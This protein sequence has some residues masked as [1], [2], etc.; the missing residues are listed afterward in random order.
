MSD[1]AVTTQ[2]GSARR[3]RWLAGPMAVLAFGLLA[4]SALAFT[5]GTAHG[6]PNTV[7]TSQSDINAGR[8]LYVAHCQSC[9]G[10]NGV[11][12]TNSSP[13]L[14]DAGAAAADFYLSTGRMPL[15]N[16]SDEAIR[17]RPYFNNTEIRQLVAYV[18]ALPAING[19][20]KSGA[21]IPTI[22]PVCSAGQLSQASPPPGATAP[23]SPAGCVDL[24]QGLQVYSLNCAQCHHSGTAG[25]MLSKGNTVPSLSDSSIL[26]IAEAPRVG[27][28]PM[29]IFG[30]GQ[31]S[32]QEISAVAQY[33]QYVKSHSNQGGLGISHFGPVAEGFVGIVI[34]LGLLLFAS[35]MIGNR[36]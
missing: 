22:L 5:G 1:P 25:G 17:H 3:R 23:T 15:N 26:Q 29:P 14:I 21:P 16:P 10:V 27:P 9:H 31:L 32:D 12:G 6:D 11:G 7:S 2:P 18:N 28:K 24:A 8:A 30:P 13:E 33:V 34:G 36:G 35:R 20:N 4:F 19:S